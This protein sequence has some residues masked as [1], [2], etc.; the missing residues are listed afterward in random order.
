MVIVLKIGMIVEA[1]KNFDFDNVKKVYFGFL[2]EHIEIQLSSCHR[3]V[4]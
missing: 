2:K 1:L 3:Y 4:Y